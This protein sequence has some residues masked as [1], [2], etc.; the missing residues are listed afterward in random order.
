MPVY[1]C[2]LDKIREPLPVTLDQAR[3]MLAGPRLGIS[4]EASSATDAPA[5][6]LAYLLDCMRAGTPHTRATSTSRED[7]GALIVRLVAAPSPHPS[8]LERAA[9]ERIQEDTRH[10]MA[11]P[12]RAPRDASSAPPSAR[13]DAPDDSPDAGSAPPPSGVGD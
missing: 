7:N 4:V 8:D 10:A 3:D 6:A 1:F 9:L 5:A 12:R 13:S 2:P 11:R